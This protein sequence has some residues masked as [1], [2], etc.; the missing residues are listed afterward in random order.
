MIVALNAVLVGLRLW[1]GLML[2]STGTT[3]GW[4]LGVAGL[5]T[6]VST[7]AAW[8]VGTPCLTWRGLGVGVGHLATLLIRP[9]KTGAQGFAVVLW[10][11]FAVQMYLRVLLWHRCTVTAPVFV[12]VVERGPYRIVRHP[13]TFCEMLIAVASVAQSPSLYNW[14]VLAFVIACK[15][16][17]TKT[18]DTFL[19]QFLPYRRYAS[20]VRW[21]WLPL[22][23]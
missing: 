11:L 8:R 23:W 2:I 1:F 3:A 18:E 13:M 7:V 22:V 14:L 6:V 21:F 4:V 20:R 16:W 5:L 17:I 15:V 10:C 19:R 12:S 9:D